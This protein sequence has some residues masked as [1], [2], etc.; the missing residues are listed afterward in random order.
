V[1]YLME[2]ERVGADFEHF[3]EFFLPCAELLD[4]GDTHLWNR[5][6]SGSNRITGPG[7]FPEK[8]LAGDFLTFI[9]DMPRCAVLTQLPIE[10]DWEV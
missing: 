7:L 8:K 4:N 1:L 3:L 6:L 10:W 9:T 2:R 5:A